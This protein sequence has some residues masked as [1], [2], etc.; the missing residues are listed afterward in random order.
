M[1][2]DVKTIVNVFNSVFGGVAEGVK[3]FR[4]SSNI[5]KLLEPYFNDEFKKANL[6]KDQRKTAMVLLEGGWYGSID[7]LI[8]CSRKL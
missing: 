6:T 7:E 2:T 5:I 3:E 1:A 8:E 4:E